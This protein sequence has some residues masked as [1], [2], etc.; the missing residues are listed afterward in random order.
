MDAASG[1]L[2]KAVSSPAAA[3]QTDADQ[4]GHCSGGVATWCS[5]TQSQSWRCADDGATCQIDVCAQGAYCCDSAGNVAKSASPHPKDGVLGPSGGACGALDF[6]G[7]CQGTTMRWCSR[8]G[9]V[10]TVDCA[11]N[12]M[13]CQVTAH[14]ARCITRNAPSVP[15]SPDPAPQPQPPID[16]TA[17]SQ[18]GVGDPCTVAGAAGTCQLVGTCSGTQTAGH[19]PGSSQVQC[20]VP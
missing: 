19:C 5:G 12:R 8:D 4:R 1:P 2:C 14:G 15:M 16:P 10:L 9:R 13:T 17:P 7:E 6:N 18:P 11:T 3:C 20:C